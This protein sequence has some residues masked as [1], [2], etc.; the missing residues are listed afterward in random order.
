MAYRSS[1]LYHRIRH[2]TI[3]QRE[4]YPASENFFIT[5]TKESATKFS[6]CC[7]KEVIT[8]RGILLLKSG[9]SANG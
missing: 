6:G 7:F 4:E 8:E 5:I 9:C 2:T 3:P 1:S